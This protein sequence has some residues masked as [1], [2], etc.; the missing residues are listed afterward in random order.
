MT[1]FI[2]PGFRQKVTD[3]AWKKVQIIA[4]KSFKQVILF[5]PQWNYHTLTD[6]VQEFNHFRKQYSGQ[7]MVL[8]FSFGSMVSYFSSLQ[9][10]TKAAI[11]CSLSPYF[12]KDLPS[13]K[14]WWRK[15]IGKRRLT[16]FQHTKFLEPASQANTQYYLLLGEKEVPQCFSRYHDALR[17]IPQ[18]C[19][20]VV[21]QAGHDIGHESYLLSLAELFKKI[22]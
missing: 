4:Q 13:L 6:W 15:A 22:S 20:I 17:K 1:L 9:L 5:Q 8:G 2:I 10:P 16:V 7:Q 18:S 3:V 11:L 19:G 12:A 14:P 21:P